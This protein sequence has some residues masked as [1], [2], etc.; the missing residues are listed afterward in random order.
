MMYRSE[1][2]FLSVRELLKMVDARDIG[3]V[4][5]VLRRLRETPKGREMLA[6][7]ASCI[8]DALRNARKLGGMP[9]AGTRC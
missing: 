1:Y 8:T 5:E 2:E 4:A 3:A 9:R 7:A 6:E